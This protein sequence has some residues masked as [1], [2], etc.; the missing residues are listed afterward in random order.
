MKML[1]AVIHSAE[2]EQVLDALIAEGYAVTFMESRGGMLRQSQ[3]SLFMALE[4]DKVPDVLRVLREN[5]RCDVSIHSGE[6]ASTSANIGGG[7]V[8]IWDLD[9]MERLTI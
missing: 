5:C 8:F 1:M 4:A 9:R 6:K 7:V 3:L 2:V